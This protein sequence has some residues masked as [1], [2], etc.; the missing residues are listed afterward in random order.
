MKIIPEQSTSLINQDSS[1]RL[2]IDTGAC[3]FFVLGMFLA[4][5][6]FHYLGLFPTA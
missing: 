5:M 2:R 6:I 3:C 4:A 1:F